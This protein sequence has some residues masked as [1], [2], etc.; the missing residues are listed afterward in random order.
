M[1]ALHRH[2]LAR[3]TPAGWSA[4]LARPWDL[5]A[6]AC[7]AHW[8]TQELP[9]VVTRQTNE[10]DGRMALG[11][12]APGRW[13]RRRL[14]LQVPRAAVTCFFD[15]PPLAD[16]VELLPRSAHGPVRA[17][18]QRLCAC[19]AT[20]RV[21]GSYG[22]QA[23]SGL[24]HIRPQS[25]LDVSVTVVGA[26]HADAATQ[27]LQR[28]D[29]ATPRL[30]GELA[31]GDGAAVAWREW[32]TWRAGRTRAVMV[33]RLDGACLERDTGWCESKTVELAS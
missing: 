1:L 9:L 14:A 17:L 19:R 16:V 24:D 21:F 18:M 11:L 2:Q 8:A 10:A 31:F 28:F 15:F 23:L 22:W 6:R 5:Q 7:L 13:G 30:D 20:T 26:T 29:S 32:A 33:K 12:S 27:V 25:D 4:I 3:L